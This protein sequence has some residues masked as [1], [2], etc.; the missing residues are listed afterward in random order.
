MQD[1]EYESRP[2]GDRKHAEQALR[3]L[4]ALGYGPELISLIV[5]ERD[6]PVDQNFESD[7]S[8]LAG[9]GGMGATGVAVGAGAGG[10]IGA[11][12][13]AAAS[14]ALIAL[15]EGAATP[16]V[17]G[18]LAAVLAGAGAGVVSGSIIGALLELGIEAEDWRTCLRNG[19]IVVVVSLKSHAD[20]K[21]VREAL[22]HS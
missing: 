2:Y 7:T 4:Q 21:S 19:G 1:I 20:R 17:V 10:L 9:R 18:P 3:R 12:V 11:I 8:P 5:D 22:M 15:T 16:F 6:L 13:A 14:I